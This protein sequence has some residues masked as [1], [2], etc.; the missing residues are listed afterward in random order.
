MEFI[1]NNKR[2]KISFDSICPVTPYSTFFLNCFP[3]VKGLD[4]LDY[5][6]GSGVL[7]IYAAHK[8][9]KQVYGIDKNELC[10]EIALENS[11]ING[12]SHIHFE[13]TNGIDLPDCFCNA[14]DVIICNPA[15][16]PSNHELPCFLDSGL[17]GVSMILNL[18]KDSK[19]LLK[20]NGELFFIRTSL[21]PQTSVENFLTAHGFTFS[22]PYDK[23]IPFRKIY[24]PLLPYLKELQKMDIISFELGEDNQ[25]YETLYLYRAI[26]R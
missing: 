5:G 2:L 24:V 15:S 17:Y 13:I 12:T 22:I 7:S 21:T 4:V 6:F 3:H 16:L 10:L 26:L 20:R 1:D 14:F 8:G 25:Y 23:V 19:K 9:A 18:I 11:R